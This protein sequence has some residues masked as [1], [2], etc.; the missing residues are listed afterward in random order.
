[1]SSA[2]NKIGIAGL[3]AGMLLQQAGYNVQILESGS[4]SGGRI[5]S[6]RING[7]LIEAGPE[8]IHGNAKETIRLLKKYHIPFV[9]ANGK[10]Y[11][12]RDGQFLETRDMNGD[13]DKLLIQMKKLKNDLPFGEFLSL[14]FPGADHHEV[15]ESAIRFAEGFDLVDIQ[16]SSTQALAAEWLAGESTQYRIPGGYHTLI[17]SMEDEFISAGGKIFFQHA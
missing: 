1:M 12:V 6:R 5:Q 3:A 7:Y 13:W 15:R 4:V 8:F 11:R 9:P 17:Q 14:Y 10:M 16:T 2:K